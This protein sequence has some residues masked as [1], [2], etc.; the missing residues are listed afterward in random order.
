M[1]TICPLRQYPIILVK[2]IIILIY[3][4]YF[5]YLSSCFILLYSF[6]SESSRLPTSSYAKTIRCSIE[7]ILEVNRFGHCCTK[8]DPDNVLITGGWSSNDSCRTQGRTN[9]AHIINLSEQK[10][11]ARFTNDTFIRLGCILIS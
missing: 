10:I 9:E 3:F 5:F 8:L 2:F 4:D 11:V 6:I 1:I 7:S